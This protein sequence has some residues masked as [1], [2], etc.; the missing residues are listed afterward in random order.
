M[1]H[2]P[3]DERKHPTQK[4]VELPSIAIRNSCS[5]GGIVYEP[6]SGSG[7]TIIAAE[8]LGRACFAMEISPA[9]VDVALKRRENLTENK[10][11]KV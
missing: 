8:Q 9:F 11:E 5:K 6:F 2:D 10:A 1:G 4:P 3:I 7:T